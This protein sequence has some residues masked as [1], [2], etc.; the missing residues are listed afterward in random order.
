MISRVYLIFNNAIINTFVYYIKT[1]CLF[2]I[3]TFVQK[4]QTATFSKSIN[5][6]EETYWIHNKGII[7]I[8][9]I[10]F[11]SVHF[12][13]LWPKCLDQ[14]AQCCMHQ[15]EDR[16]DEGKVGQPLVSCVGNAL[17]PHLQLGITQFLRKW[18][19]KWCSNKVIYLFS[20][21]RKVLSK[22]M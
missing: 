6:R 22:V 18:S 10:R 19:V 21:S 14:L 5:W 2:I 13:A 8:S 4:K 15:A 7:V 12:F 3:K 11:S 17:L 1:Y 9:P 16:L 20:N